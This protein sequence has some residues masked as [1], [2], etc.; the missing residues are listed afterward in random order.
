MISVWVRNIEDKAYRT[1]GADAT[2]FLG[3][4]L[5]FVGDPRTYG[6]DVMFTF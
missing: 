3:T 1:L 4:T 6:V 5:H 2:A